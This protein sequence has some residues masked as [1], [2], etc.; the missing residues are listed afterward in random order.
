MVPVLVK[1][2]SVRV[3]VACARGCERP[4]AASAVRDVRAVR[5]FIADCAAQLHRIN[6]GR[7]R[8]SCTYGAPPLFKGRLRRS[9]HGDSNVT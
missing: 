5:A 1:R 2:V 4:A 7:G 9:S 8:G 3:C 6:E